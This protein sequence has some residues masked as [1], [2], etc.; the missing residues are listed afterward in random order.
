M[1]ES[2]QQVFFNS[3][4]AQGCV[5]S[6]SPSASPSAPSLLLPHAPFCSFLLPIKAAMLPSKDGNGNRS[7][8]PRGIYMY[9]HIS[10]PKLLLGLLGLGVIQLSIRLRF[11]ALRML[12]H[13]SDW[14]GLDSTRLSSRSMSIPVAR[15]VDTDLASL[16]CRGSQQLIHTRK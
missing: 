6:R 7:P 9:I 1:A 4:S 14:V 12:L 16:R 15:L 10:I 2:R 11:G 5:P 8:S 13:W 3:R